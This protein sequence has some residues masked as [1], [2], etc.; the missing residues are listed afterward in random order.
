LKDTISLE[1]SKFLEYLEKVKPEDSSKH[2][3]YLY[4]LAKLLA[5]NVK[6][7]Y[8]LYEDC[9]GEISSGQ[10]VPCNDDFEYNCVED[11]WLCCHKKM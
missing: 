7:P 5:A 8:T 2:L 9:I 3:T 6:R 1:C 4:N 10:I 11:N